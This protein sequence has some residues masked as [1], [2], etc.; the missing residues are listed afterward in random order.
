MADLPGASC[1]PAPGV[2]RSFDIDTSM[3]SGA[4]NITLS[5]DINR[6]LITMCN[7]CYGTLNDVNTQL[8]E[9]PSKKAKVNEHL[10]KINK[11]YKGSQRVHHIVE[12]IYNNIGLENIKKRIIKPLGLNIAVHYGCHVLKPHDNKPWETGCEDPTFLDEMV[13]VAGCKSIP[14]KNK[15]M[16]CGAGGVSARE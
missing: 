7:G 11:E 14:Y 13:E 15:L 4:R 10:K 3:T 8:K 12:I 6:D 16:C 1:C 9:D 5:E 2:F